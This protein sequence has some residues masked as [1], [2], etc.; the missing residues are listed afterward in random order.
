MKE[1]VLIFDFGNVVGF[2]DYLRACERFAAHRGM[3][4]PAFRDQLIDRGFGRLLAEFECGRIAPVAFA[5]RV[6]ERSGIRLPYQ[7]FV[8]AWEDIF[9]PNESIA[10]LLGFLKSR[11][12]PLFLGSNTNILHATFYRRQFAETLDLFDGFILSYEVGHMKP[13]REFFDACAR[14][15]G[16]PASSCL[17]IDDI[18]ENVDGARAAGLQALQYVNTSTLLGDLARAGVEVPG[19]RAEG[20]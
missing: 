11:G 18:A 6:M 1:P 3:T 4:G 15:A 8:R 7:D 9:W 10:E 16:V 12:Y 14:A 5:D 13:A 19:A 17:F 2:F 20:P